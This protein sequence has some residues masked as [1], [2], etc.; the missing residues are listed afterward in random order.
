MFCRVT[1]SPDLIIIIVIVPQWGEL[2]KLNMTRC[3]GMHYGVGVVC[4]DQAMIQNTRDLII[5]SQLEEKAAVTYRSN[6][7]L[8]LSADWL[9][10]LLESCQGGHKWKS[11][12]RGCNHCNWARC[13]APGSPSCD[14]GLAGIITSRIDCKYHLFSPVNILNSC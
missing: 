9:T 10:L 12:N 11:C 4:C 1:S 6:L 2:L 13:K 14:Y 8:S 5:C 3:V 7:Q